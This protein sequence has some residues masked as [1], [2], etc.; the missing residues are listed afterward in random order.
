MELYVNGKLTVAHA[1]P[2]LSLLRFL[3]DHLRLTGTK[4]GCSEGH[5]GTCTVLVDGQPTRS[6]LLK[7]AQA[8]GKRVE[9]IEG[10]AQDG[11]LHPLQRALIDVGAIQCGFCIPGMVIS[12]KALLDRNLQPS[13]QEIREALRLNL[14]RCGGYLKIIEAVQSAARVLIGKAG[15]E[16]PTRYVGKLV[17]V[18]AP[19]K[20]GE[21]KATGE[22][23]FA[24]DIY[25]DGMLF[26]KVLLARHPHAEILALD[27]SQAERMPG[28][29][30]VLTAGDVPGRETFG[31]LV[32]DQPVLANT[33]VRFLGDVVAAVFAESLA[34]AEQARD[35]VDVEYRTLPVVSSP[36]EA[37]RADAPRLSQQGNVCAHVHL[38]AV[39]DV[40]KGFAQADVVVEGDYTTPFVEHGY[41]EPEAAV[42]IP[43]PDGR[44]TIHCPTQ[45]PFVSRIGIATF[46]NVSQ[47]SVRIVC[48]PLGGGFGGKTDITAPALAAL[49][50]L[51]TGRP[52]KL[53]L[54]R[55]ESLLMSTKKHASA[56]HYKVGATKDGSLTAVEA[57]IVL[58][59]GPYTNLSLR[60]LE[61]ACVFACG[62]YVVP[63]VRI[64]GLA[65][66]TNNGNGGA[67]RGLGINQVAFAMESCLDILARKLRMDPFELRLRNALEVGKSTI[68][69][70][71]LRA[72]VPVKETL[73]AARA[74]L[75]AMSSVKSDKKIGIGVAAGFKNVGQGKG[76]V[77]DAGAIVELTEEGDVLA[78]VS[79]VDMGQGNRT[80]LAQLA[81]EVIGVGYDRIKLITGDTD[82]V[83]RCTGIAA[84]ERQT[85]C[86][87]NAILG[88]AR[89]F[90]D[91]VLSYVA[92]GYDVPIEEL[93]IE[94][95]RVVAGDSVLLTLG[96][97]GQFTAKEGE[98]LR[99]DYFYVA[100][101][102]YTFSD[103]DVRFFGNPATRD[104]KVLD[105]SQI[106]AEEYRNYPSYAYTTHVAIVEVDER[107]GAVKVLK[108]IAAHDVGR[109]L[110]PSKIEGQLQGATIMGLGYALK[111]EYRLEK[112][113]PLTKN[114]GQC[115]IP[116]I[117]DAPEIEC[118]IVE[119]PD[120]NGP[121]GA[122]GISEVATVPITPAIANAVYDAVGVRITSLPITRQK[123]TDA[124]KRRED[125]QNVTA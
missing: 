22:L 27:T 36:E 63:N 106:S 96:E 72:S 121:L 8:K 14:C 81:A 101:K 102:T 38:A 15:P 98:V 10:I 24:D 57:N 18:S 120:P 32:P 112:G 40:E 19:D 118:L 41:L 77:D 107:T 67:M 21:L 105:R 59:A 64:E 99:A 54:T 125:S 12:G 47:E 60:V 9:T 30:T 56:L 17:G 31:A 13:T 83:P 50:A 94:D 43:S 73:E 5:C 4:N 115:H 111:E 84:G 35:A 48:T 109:I 123:V 90:R 104:G 100:P 80:I 116:T 85:F 49:A 23:E 82:L 88:A 29:A 26:G 6:C 86:A 45:G 97:L 46:L 103:L 92:Q 117:K 16:A 2:E 44:V 53:T 91:R 39:G 11:Q 76:T 58:D 95:D 79:T 78:R 7:L 122:K 37:L 93:A 25:A 65:V 1:P 20:E 119:D 55:A 66:H 108:V 62:P 61:Q 34:E 51:R 110:N 113:I 69:G 68:T 74:S 70:E 114:L 89:L 87:G 124:L 42:A 3:R 33:R 28:V 52:C 71:I 75:R